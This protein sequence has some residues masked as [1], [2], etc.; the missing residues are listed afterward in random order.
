PRAASGGGSTR[1]RRVPASLW[2]P[3]QLL[4][5]MP[6]AA[7]TPIHSKHDDPSCGRRCRPSPTWSAVQHQPRPACSLGAVVSDPLGRLSP[8]VGCELHHSTSVVN[9][10]QPARA[11]SGDPEINSRETTLIIVAKDSQS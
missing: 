3:C 4:L 11:P 10:P 2:W 6:G 8:A 7:S 5:D 9:A 1:G